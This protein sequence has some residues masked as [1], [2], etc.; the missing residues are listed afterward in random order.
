MLR[1]LINGTPPLLF[2]VVHRM[3]FAPLFLTFCWTSCCVRPA[4]TWAVPCRVLTIFG[5]CAFGAGFADP[6]RMR[7]MIKIDRPE[8]GKGD[9]LK[10]SKS[11]TKLEC[12][13]VCIL[14]VDRVLTEQLCP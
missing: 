3:K 13:A 4:G 9:V 8:I 14:D 11:R 12:V 1:S 6:A 7:G 5:T 10:R 2:P